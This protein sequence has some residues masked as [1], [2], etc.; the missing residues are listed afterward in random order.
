M[1][2]S[3]GAIATP[4]SDESYVLQYGPVQSATAASSTFLSRQTDRYQYQSLSQAQPLTRTTTHKR[5]RLIC[6]ARGSHQQLLSLRLAHF[7]VHFELD[8]HNKP[9]Y[10][11]DVQVAVHRD[12]FL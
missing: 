2:S 11:F 3:F 6:A 8:N 10:D 5:K 12:K 1:S 7:V 9:R 4:G